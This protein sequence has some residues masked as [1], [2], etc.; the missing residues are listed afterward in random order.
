MNRT[1][2]IMSVPSM[3]QQGREEGGRLDRF[4]G[5]NEEPH[6]CSFI[7]AAMS[8]K[9]APRVANKSILN[10]QICLPS[11]SAEAQC[12]DR[13]NREQACST[14]VSFRVLHCV[15]LFRETERLWENWLITKTAF[16]SP[17]CDMS[18]VCLVGAACHTR[19]RR[20]GQN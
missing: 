10:R 5:M 1:S 16:P 14:F 7:A 15:A 2:A 13:A 18:C 17:Q 6:S 19:E 4:V 12:L 20:E 8:N 9:P 11:S 3:V